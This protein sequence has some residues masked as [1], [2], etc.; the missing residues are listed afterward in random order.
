ME[1]IYEK[2]EEEEVI[3]KESILPPNEQKQLRERDQQKE[4]TKDAI[5]V[6]EVK[7]EVCESFVNDQADLPESDTISELNQS[8]EKE[9]CDRQIIIHDVPMKSSRKLEMKA[10]IKRLENLIAITKEDISRLNR[11]PSGEIRLTFKDKQ[12][13]DDIIKKNYQKNVLNDGPYNYFLIDKNIKPCLTKSALH[14]LKKAQQEVNKKNAF[15]K[16]EGD[17]FYVLDG[18]PGFR[19]G[20]CVRLV[21]SESKERRDRQI[22]IYDLN[23]MESQKE[24]NLES[25]EESNQKSNR[26][27]K[28]VI[29]KLEDLVTITEEDISDL[30]QMAPGTIHVTFKDKQIVDDIMM[31]NCQKNVLPDGTF[32]YTLI[33]KSIKAC[34]TKKALHNVQ[35]ANQE[36]DKKNALLKD[37]HFYVLDGDPGFRNGVSVRL[38]KKDAIGVNEVKAE[39]CVDTLS[40]KTA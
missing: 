27:L 4:V 9:L 13:V 31:K 36:R 11:L 40:D 2:S 5:E 38:V 18:D 35:K 7:A 10:V 26:E 12:I 16:E 25:N 29:K 21:K 32:Y 39:V 28:A 15:L 30:H 34:L 17:H 22:I 24:S 6:N 8:R 1:S 37:D 23:L 20:A 33:D 14:E 19:N 3:E